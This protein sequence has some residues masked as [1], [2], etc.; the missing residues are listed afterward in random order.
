M[1]DTTCRRE[2]IRNFSDRDMILIE[3]QLNIVKGFRYAN[4]H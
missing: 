4:G 3:D 1:A 2:A